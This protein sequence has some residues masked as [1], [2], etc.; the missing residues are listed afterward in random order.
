MTNIT[1]EE[2]E[3]ANNSIESTLDHVMGLQHKSNGV[4]GFKE[5]D[6]YSLRLFQVEALHAAAAYTFKR[7][8]ELEGKIE[9][10]EAR[11]QSLDKSCLP[12][13]YITG[14]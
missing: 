7:I 5:D 12:G 9:Q 6:L 3:A 14:I 8:D 4:F 11:I 2:A 1:R 13:A 10:L